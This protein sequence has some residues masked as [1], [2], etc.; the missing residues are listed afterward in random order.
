MDKGLLGQAEFGGDLSQAGP[1]EAAL[2]EQPL[3][4]LEEVAAGIADGDVGDVGL[5]G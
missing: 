3:G 2:G 4:R 1:I 5:Q